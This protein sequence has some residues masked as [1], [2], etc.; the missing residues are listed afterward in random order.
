LGARQRH[1]EAVYAAR[2]DGELSWFDP[3][4]S[5]T[6]DLV[7]ACAA[8]GMAVIDVGGGS[9]ALAGRLIAA[10]LGPVTVLDLSEAALARLTERLDPRQR[11]LLATIVAEVT[12]WEPPAAAFG[13][14]HDRAAFHFLTQAADRAA[15]VGAMDRA[16]A[17]GGHAVIVTF[18]ED[19][20]DRCSGLPVVRYAPDALA[21]EIDRHAPGRFRPVEARRIAHSTPSGGVQRMQ[22]SVFR[23][24]LGPA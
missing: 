23:K 9:S 10:G 13:L 4:A 24:A 3:M 20:P 18:A 22:A 19:G 16:L 14:W 11:A 8:P 1:W 2:A 21:A 17:R 7:A 12:E 6:F 5:E 15:Y